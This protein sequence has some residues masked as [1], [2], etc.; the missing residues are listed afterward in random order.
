MG[1]DSIRIERERDGFKVCATD[2]EI[3]K[4]NRMRDRSRES[5]SK[6]DSPWRDP[7]VEFQ[8]ETKEQALAFVDKAMDIALPKDEYSTAFDNIVKQVKGKPD[9]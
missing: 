4:A 3:A 9:E 5:D 1:Y 8:F 7:N 2:P 6:S